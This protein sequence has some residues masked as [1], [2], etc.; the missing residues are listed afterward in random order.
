MGN[1]VSMIHLFVYA[2]VYKE[3][4]ILRSDRYQG[5]EMTN[6]IWGGTGEI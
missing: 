1:D 3:T 4:C 2:S 6:V 5:F